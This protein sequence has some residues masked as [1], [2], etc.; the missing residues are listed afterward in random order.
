[1]SIAEYIHEAESLM[2]QGSVDEA[3]KSYTTLARME[4]LTLDERGAV[5]FGLGTC[6]FIQEQYTA[7][8]ALLQES[9]EL[10][11]SARGARDPLTT[12][13]MVLLSRTL[14]ALGNLET[15]M[16]VGHGALKNL[17]ELYG[18]D[19][20][21]TA[22]AAFFLSAGAYRFGRLA[23]A[24]SLIRQAMLAWEKLYGHDSLQVASCLDALGKLHD[25]CG[26]KREGVH[27]HR[28]AL[29]IKLQVL[30]EQENTAAALGHLGMALAKLEE[31]KEAEELLDRALSCFERIGTASDAGG[32][33]AFRE[34]LEHCRHMTAGEMDNGQKVTH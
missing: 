14:I 19:N 9:W 23:E 18:L 10:L 28:Q 12:R 34:E 31:W 29:E 25:D 24:E 2:R 17:E 32:T 4:H 5:L 11:L 6:R 15:G 13:T 26:E 30:G 27:L 16:E 3:L 22:T 7:A 1:M 21:Q 33:R 8:A 20:E